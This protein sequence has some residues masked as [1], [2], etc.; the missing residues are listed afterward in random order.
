MSIRVDTERSHHLR[1]TEFSTECET[2]PL[3]HANRTSHM[4]IGLFCDWFCSWF[5]GYHLKEN[6]RNPVHR[7]AMEWPLNIFTQEYLAFSSRLIALAS[8]CESLFI[9]ANVDGPIPAE[10][11]AEMFCSGAMVSAFHQNGIT[12]SSMSCYN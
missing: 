1:G 12:F 8:T 5:S 10:M 4:N 11:I 9:G 3:A 2:G 6:R 7:Q